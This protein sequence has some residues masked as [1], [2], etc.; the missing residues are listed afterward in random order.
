VVQVAGPAR[1]DGK[2]TQE[3]AIAGTPA[4]MSPEQADSRD[5]LDAR[6]DIYSLG[7]VAYFLLTGRPPFVRATA[8]QILAAHMLEPVVAPDQVCAVPA[9]LQ[10]VVLRCLAKDPAER[11]AGAEDLDRALAACSDSGR[12]D[13]EQARAWWSSRGQTGNRSA[14]EAFTVEAAST[15][16]GH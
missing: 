6:T 15:P 12:W 4:F 7:A 14:S 11:F 13:E 10:A 16:P 9:D 2:L 3:G 5:S 8:M 1:A